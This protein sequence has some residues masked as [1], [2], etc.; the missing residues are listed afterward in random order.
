MDKVLVLSEDETSLAMRTSH[1]R[2]KP[3]WPRCGVTPKTQIL[4]RL[5]RISVSCAISVSQ[6]RVYPDIL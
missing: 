4:A 1:M 6:I 2:V 5:M 3:Y